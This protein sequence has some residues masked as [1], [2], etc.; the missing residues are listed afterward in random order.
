MDGLAVSAARY[1]GGVRWI[2]GESHRPDYLQVDHK[3]PHS[4]QGKD[5]MDNYGLLCYPCNR[6][7]SNK[8][9]LGELRQARKA[10]ARI[11]V[12]WYEERAC[13]E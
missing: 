7:K 3:K 9:S 1:G 4:L 10:E 6:K 2:W 12:D 13:W 11:D 8:M 5:D